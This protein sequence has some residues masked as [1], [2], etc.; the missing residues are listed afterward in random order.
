MG[1]TKKQTKTSFGNGKKLQGQLEQSTRGPRWD[2]IRRCQ[3]RLSK[4]APRTNRSETY[5]GRNGIGAIPNNERYEGSTGRSKALAARHGADDQ[6]TKGQ[7]RVEELWRMVR[8]GDWMRYGAMG[9]ICRVW[10]PWP[11]VAV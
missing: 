7:R 2:D 9:W 8:R 3:T 1:K 11:G 6:K 10:I 5:E 4:I